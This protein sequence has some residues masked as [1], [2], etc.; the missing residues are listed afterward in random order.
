[1][2]NRFTLKNVYIFNHRLLDDTLDSGSS[3][4]SHGLSVWQ[5]LAR[6]QFARPLVIDRLRSSVNEIIA[7]IGGGSTQPIAS[8]VSSLSSYCTQTEDLNS[9]SEHGTI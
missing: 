6:N 9:V 5:R 8:I 7:Q 3:L 1:V 2:L 4:A